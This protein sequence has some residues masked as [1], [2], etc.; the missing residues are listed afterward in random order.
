MSE[1][2]VGGKKADELCEPGIETNSMKTGT[3][4][5]G[6]SLHRGRYFRM[7]HIST[8]IIRTQLSFPSLGPRPSSPG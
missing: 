3:L 5:S 2:W 4:P 6:L 7:S 1:A 8:V